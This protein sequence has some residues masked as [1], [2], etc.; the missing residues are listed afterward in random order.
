MK[1][2]DSFILIKN[3]ILPIITYGNPTLRKQGH[4]IKEKNIELDD[5]IDNMFQT[6][7]HADGVGLTAHQIDKPLSLFVVNYVNDD[8]NLKEV[9]INPEIIE[10]SIDEDYY[11]EGCLSIPDIKE[12]IKRPKSIKIKYL[13]K[14]F[15]QKESIFEGLIARIIQHEYDH[16][17]GVLFIDKL[18]PIRKRLL[19]SKINKIIK[20]KFFVNYRTK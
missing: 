12:E 19:S 16:I 6:L 7:Y 10:Y 17:K 20:K 3:M 15:N 18:S 8:E 4:I 2:V 13:D 14:N 9:F 11:V 5:L 1:F